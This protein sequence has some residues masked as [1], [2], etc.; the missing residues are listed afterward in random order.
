VIW[1]AAA[2]VVA[3]IGGQ[4]FWIARALGEVGRRLDRIDARLD[5]I[6][7]RVLEDYGQRIARLEERTGT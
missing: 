4:A 3:A 5:R 2:V 6:E 1:A 7:T